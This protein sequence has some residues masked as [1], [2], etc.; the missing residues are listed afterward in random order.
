MIRQTRQISYAPSKK[1]V[2]SEAFTEVFQ[3]NGSGKYF[4]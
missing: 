4:L 1:F 2:V 3:I